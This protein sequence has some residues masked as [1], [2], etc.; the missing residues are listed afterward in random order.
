VA[1]ATA[2][3]TTAATATAPSRPTDNGCSVA[4]TAGSGAAWWLLLAPAVLLVR[5]RP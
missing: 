4:P 5:R 1:P 3:H 2:T